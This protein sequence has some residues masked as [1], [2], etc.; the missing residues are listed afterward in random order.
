[1]TI[2]DLHPTYFKSQTKKKTHPVRESDLLLACQVYEWDGVSPQTDLMKKIDAARYR[3]WEKSEKLRVEDDEKIFESTW[4]WTRD[5]ARV[6][7]IDEAVLAQT[8]A[9]LDAGDRENGK[10]MATREE[11]RKWAMEKL[12]P[13][14]LSRRFGD[15]PNPFF[16]D[17]PLRAWE[18]INHSVEWLVFSL[19]WPAATRSSLA[20]RFDTTA[21]LV[22]TEYLDITTRTLREIL[23]DCR[24]PGSCHCRRRGSH[25][26][27]GCHRRRSS[28][29]SPC[30]SGP[31]S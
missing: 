14:V 13:Y 3:Q 31:T 25:H 4:E 7:S 8:M 29:L 20:Q 9:E 26:R 30:C 6:N 11:Q 12:V 22:S 27:P 5:E 1:M 2:E 23:G 28:A 21:H 18:A 10:P 19:E 16:R 17:I 24:D 15:V